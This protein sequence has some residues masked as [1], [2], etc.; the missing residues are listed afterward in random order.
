MVQ[1]TF[2]VVIIQY[3][4]NH[5]LKEFNM[6]LKCSIIVIVPCNIHLIVLARIKKSLTIL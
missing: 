3:Y 5:E 1:M 2:P 6:H 4:L